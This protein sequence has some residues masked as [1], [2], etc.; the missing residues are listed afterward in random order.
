[1]EIKGQ[2]WILPLRKNNANIKYAIINT[3]STQRINNADIIGTD[4]R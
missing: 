4:R 1:M 3:N 2:K